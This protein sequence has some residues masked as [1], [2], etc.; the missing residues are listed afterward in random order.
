MSDDHTPRVTRLSVTPI[1]GLALHHPD[2]I[3][4]D[5]SGA[6]GDRD[7]YMVD[8][9]GKLLSIARCGGFV[10][11]H[12]AFDRAAGR[13]ELRDAGGGLVAG[14]VRLG[15]PVTTDFWGRPVA[16]HVVEGPWAERLSELAGRDV[17]LVK[18]DA[19]GAGSDEE[20]VTLMGEASL[21]ELARR[22]DLPE[23]D[24]RRFRMLIE[25]SSSEPHVEDTWNGRRLDVGT[26]ALRIGGPVPR[27]AATTR[28][29]DH[30]DRDLPTVRLIR[31]YRGMQ[32]GGV[33]FGVYASVAEGGTVRVGD[34]LRLRAA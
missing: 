3:E 19:P 13:L 23:V 24:G 5:H 7:L 25:F 29:P 2:A 30:G 12:A 11:V 27:C 1:K 20:P 34:A 8:A 18:T 32:Q 16:G 21:R 15:E 26:A 9:D 6:V 28:H 4:L 14:T 31:N 22:S 33:N 10:G 17:R